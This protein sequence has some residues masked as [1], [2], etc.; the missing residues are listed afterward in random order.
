MTRTIPV[1]NCE[2]PGSFST[3]QHRNYYQRSPYMTIIV[4]ELHVGKL[5]LI[6]NYVP[7]RRNA[8]F[9]KRDFTA[10]KTLRALNY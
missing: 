3:N 10:D 1:N 9:Y 5:Q 8:V 4:R 6:L 7:T 2:L